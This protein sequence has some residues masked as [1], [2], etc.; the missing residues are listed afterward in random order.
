MQSF[1]PGSRGPNGSRSTTPAA[2]T[3]AGPAPAPH[4]AMTASASS[5]PPSSKSRLN[6]IDLLCSGLEDHVIDTHTL[7]YWRDHAL[8]TRAHEQLSEGESRFQN[9]RA[10]NRHL[11]ELVSK[12]QNGSSSSAARNTIN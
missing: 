10:W 11:D 5:E 3:R 1:E 4:W 2:A 12:L 6:F 8:G 7:Q 9:T